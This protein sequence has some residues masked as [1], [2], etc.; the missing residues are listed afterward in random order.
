MGDRLNT[1]LATIATVRC[2]LASTMFF[3]S[4]PQIFSV[5]MLKRAIQ[6]GRKKPVD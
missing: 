4:S 1:P 2:R 3:M 5:M 6:Q